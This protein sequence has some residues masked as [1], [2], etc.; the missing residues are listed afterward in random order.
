ML[1]GPI[2]V[3]VFIHMANFQIWMLEMQIWLKRLELQQLWKLGQ[4]VLTTLLLPV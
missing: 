2:N 4:V 1:N 3:L